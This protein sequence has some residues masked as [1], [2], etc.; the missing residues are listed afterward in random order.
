[1]SRKRSL[2]KT[3][4]KL[5]RFTAEQDVLLERAAKLRAEKV[6]EIVTATEIAREG[7]ILLAG[8]IVLG[9]AA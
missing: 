1:M 4:P 9:A 5:I 6:G 2:V 7:A 8:Q 3:K